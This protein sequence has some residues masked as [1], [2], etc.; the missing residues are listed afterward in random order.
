MADDAIPNPLYA[1]PLVYDI[2]ATPGTAR[3][4]NVLQR[5]A[6]RWVEGANAGREPRRWLEPACG[7]GRY[8]RLAA[9]RGLR[10]TGFDASPAMVG[11]ARATLARRGLSTLA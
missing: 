4:L 2:L 11:Y 6:S 7:T 9:A 5:I 8:L 1:D 3:E 10:V